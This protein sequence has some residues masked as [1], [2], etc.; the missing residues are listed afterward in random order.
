[1]LRLNQPPYN[2]SFLGVLAAAAEHYAMD[3]PVSTLYGASGHAFLTNV[4]RDLCPSGPYVWDH[5]RV[6]D[7]LR[8]IGLD[9]TDI[10]FF[11][12]DSGADE[13]E[14][15]EARLQEHLDDGTVCGVVNLDHQLILG[16]EHGRFVLG[17]PWGDAPTTPPT[18][19]SET[20]VEF[21]DDIHALFYAVTRCDPVDERTA[22]VDA[23]RFAIDL[24]ERPREYVEPDYGIG[25][26]AYDNWIGA[27]LA[28]SG[29]GH[30]AWWNAMVWAEC[31]AE[32]ASYLRRLASDA[33]AIAD[34][35]RDAAE[36]YNR[37]AGHLRAAA[38]RELDTELKL[39]A[40]R[41]ARD[42][43]Q[44]AVEQLVD[45]VRGL[46]EADDRS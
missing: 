24:Y 42:D 3:V 38:D 41:R 28:G 2:V 25:P 23:L 27:V 16:Y 4:H 39:A 26:E 19:S 18:L 46:T 20:W 31:K 36:K 5:S 14:A 9:V 15:L 32:A 34:R 29:S 10:G 45:V 8:N 44:E 7:L 37:V 12:N 30:G 11:T 35:A 22:A 17:Q 21:G 43:E 6:F 1:M 40:V 13:R 33:P